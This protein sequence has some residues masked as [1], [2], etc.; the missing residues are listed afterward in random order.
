LRFSV[1]SALHRYARTLCSQN[2][3]ML[4]GV[5]LTNG[6]LLTPEIVDGILSLGLR[7]MI[8]L[9]GI[10]EYHDCQRPFPGREGSFETV[11][12]AVD[13]A[14]SRGLVPDISITISGRSA[15][16]L[17]GTME[18]VLER[19]LPFSLNFY[20]ES[21]R[22]ASNT[23]LQLEEQQVINGML[24]AY[25]VIESN[26][27]DCSLLASL[28]DRANLAV[29]HL[30]PCH[31]G[32]SYLVFDCQGYVAKCQMDIGRTITHS[33]DPDP[34]RTL[35]ESD[36]GIH[37]LSVGEKSECRDC[38]WR[39]WCA[40]GCPLQAFRKTERYD[41]KSPNCHIYRALYPQ[42]LRLEGLRLLKYAC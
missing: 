6:T 26:L 16:G 12:R 30:R 15:D 17:P 5:V 42:V 27:P 1:V 19:D 11:S 10:G 20:R 31:V 14:L 9:D 33:S 23:D 36:V 4:D 18:W 28:I 34:L 7:L 41:A 3:L 2:E 24:A 39:Y 22:S 29:P 40:G 25:Q 13:L 32:C 21:D 38:E 37:N 35:R 8:S